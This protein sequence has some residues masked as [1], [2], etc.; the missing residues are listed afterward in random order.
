MGLVFLRVIRGFDFVTGAQH[1]FLEVRT[2]LLYKYHSV[3]TSSVGFS[4]KELVCT[5]YLNPKFKKETF[6]LCMLLA[7]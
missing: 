6:I 1:V 4:P 3:L 7:N 2:K 5:T